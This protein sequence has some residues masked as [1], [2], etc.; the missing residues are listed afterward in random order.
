[1]HL[2]TKPV[3]YFSPQNSL[4]EHI[5]FRSLLNK[6]N[7]EIHVCPPAWAA[8]FQVP[9]A[10]HDAHYAIPSPIFATGFDA[11]ALPVTG[12]H[13]VN[14]ARPLHVLFSSNAEIGY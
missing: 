14:P 11:P 8:E 3:W 4:I 9:M 2:R 6:V 5:D 7:L 13:D 12:P 1:M 10:Y